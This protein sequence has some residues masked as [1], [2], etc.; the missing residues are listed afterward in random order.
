MKTHTPFAG[1]GIDKSGTLYHLPH[2]LKM[3]M[4]VGIFVHGQ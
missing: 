4:E 2:S 1:A 3:K